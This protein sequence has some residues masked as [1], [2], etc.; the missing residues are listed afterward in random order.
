MAP[1]ENGWRAWLK[2]KQNELY[3][4]FVFCCFFF[5]FFLVEFCPGDYHQG[6]ANKKGKI[7]VV[8]WR[9]VL[10]VPMWILIFI[11]DC[12]ILGWGWSVSSSL[13]LYRKHIEFVTAAVLFWWH[14]HFWISRRELRRNLSTTHRKAQDNHHSAPLS[15]GS[16]K[17]ITYVSS[18][19]RK[20]LLINGLQGD[21]SPTC[22]QSNEISSFLPL[23]R[24]WFYANTLK[25]HRWTPL[26]KSINPTVLIYQAEKQHWLCCKAKG[27]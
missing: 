9:A 15:D 16:A 26:K 20:L 12:G 7:S 17:W 6:D 3:G 27:D 24:I 2:L 5:F 4:L 14:Q 22:V 11:Y 13:N 1:L 23:Y 25:S 18:R 21:F 8:T 19:V 10:F